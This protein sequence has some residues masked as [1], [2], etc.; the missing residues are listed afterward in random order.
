[1]PLMLVEALIGDGDVLRIPAL[2]VAALVAVT[3]S[4][5]IRARSKPNSTRTSVPPEDPGQSSF[6]FG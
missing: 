6:M 4:I 3:S 5:A 1:M 2:P